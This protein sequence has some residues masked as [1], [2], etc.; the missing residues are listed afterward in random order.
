M[1]ARNEGTFIKTLNLN[2]KNDRKRLQKVNGEKVRR[3]GCLI[4]S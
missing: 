2:I 4:K 1:E 3:R